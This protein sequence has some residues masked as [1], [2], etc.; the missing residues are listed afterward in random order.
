[1]SDEFTKYEHSKRRK[2]NIIAKHLKDTG[3]HKGAFAM[4]IHDARKEE[5]KRVHIKPTQII[6]DGD[7]EDWDT[8]FDND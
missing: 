7:E 8:D 1:M 2:R 4:K 5:Y 3:D 6:L